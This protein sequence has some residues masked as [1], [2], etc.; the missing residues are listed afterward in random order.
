M[1]NVECP[2]CSAPYSVSEKRIPSSGLKMRCPKCAHTFVVAHPSAGEPNATGAV[3]NV[4]P[5]AELRPPAAPIVPASAGS[6]EEAALDG[7]FGDDSIEEDSKATRP[8][9][10]PSAGFGV[11]DLGMDASSRASRHTARGG[12]GLW[13][14]KGEEPAPGAGDEAAAVDELFGDELDLPSAPDELPAPKAAPAQQQALGGEGGWQDGDDLPAPTELD[15]PEPVGEADLPRPLPDSAQLPSPADFGEHDIDMSDVSFDEAAPAPTSGELPMPQM[16]DAGL[17]FPAGGDAGAPP[18]KSADV[19]DEFALEQQ[20]TE[21]AVSVAGE[22]RAAESLHA[23][24]AKVRLRKRKKKVRTLAAAGILAT[25]AGGMLTL[26]DA[27]PF[28]FYA[29]ADVVQAGTHRE[30][31][32]AR[33]ATTLGVLGEDTASAARRA[34]IAADNELKTMPRYSEL[35]GYVSFVGMITVLRFGEKGSLLADAR[36]KLMLLKEKQGPLVLLARAG[37][38]AV[39]EKYK[40]AIAAV[41]AL[42]GGFA[43]DVDAQALAGECAL[44]LRDGKLALEIWKVADKAGSSPRTLY[45]MARSYRLLRRFKKAAALSKRVLAASK[46]HAGARELL[47]STLAIDPETGK[48][49]RDV[50]KEMEGLKL[51][52]QVT[53]KGPIHDSASKQELI[54]AY[55]TLGRIQLSHSRL[56][57]AEKA[58]QAALKLNPR[59]V[60]ALVG[61]GRLMFKA[62]RYNEALARFQSAKQV[63]PRSVP[64]AIGVAMVKINQERA[65]EASEELATLIAKKSD[66]HAGYWLGMAYLGLGRRSA[67]EE[68]LRQVIAKHPSDV[69]S[70]AAYVKLAELL[71]SSGNE[72][73]AA[74]VLA[75]AST[76]VPPSADLFIAKG[77]MNLHSGRLA[78]AKQEFKQALNLDAR[79]LSALFHLAVAQRRGREF[80]AASTTFDK[81]ATADSTYPGLA[82]ER[83]LLF[84]QTD[85]VD[86]ALAMYS[87][88][89]KAAPNDVDLML[90]VGSTLVVSEQPKQ[91]ITILKKVYKV[92]RTSAE[93]NHFLG[94]ALLLDGKSAKAYDFLNAAA[95]IEP[96]NATYQLYLGWVANAVG[97]LAEAESALKVALELDRKMADAF[98]QRGVLLQKRGKTQEALEDFQIALELKPSRYQAYANIAVCLQQRTQYDEAE[99]A[100]RKALEGNNKQHVWHFRLG[101]ILWDRNAKEEAAKHLMMAVDLSGKKLADKKLKSTPR[102]LWYANFLLGEAL[103]TSNPKRAI[104]AYKTYLEHAAEEDAYRGDAERALRALKPPR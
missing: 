42:G 44:A 58:F 61:H 2:S 27:G 16:S 59:S 65:K 96:N 12:S 72:K 22:E 37:L 50:K 40:E 20:T 75:A 36:Q 67:A 90:R 69:R 13:G 39:D 84:E 47:A 29:L 63:Q 62:G 81:V 78:K 93:V 32:A 49:V 94:R 99:K 4:P 30:K 70:V 104:V 18:Q 53:G 66:P 17:P 48:A 33:R 79:N 34:Y 1:I 100:W 73:D 19:G 77:E 60:D 7:L 80:E 11:L 56:G 87:N 68:A 76:K 82:L 86:K 38:L 55:T 26:T 31:T 21:G 83:G 6:E 97:R 54:A 24:A 35:S 15:L 52:E 45:G 102:W 3:S 43:N 85:R 103:R 8:A 25:V 98:W 9:S 14:I 95:R 91:A 41:K 57:D 71:A 10:Q 89:L 88:A 74:T 23:A 92:R 46:Q 28:G 64:A 101:K 5:A 51:L